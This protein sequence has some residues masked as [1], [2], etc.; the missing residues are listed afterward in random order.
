[1]KTVNHTQKKWLL[2]SCL[3]AAL[4]ANTSLHFSAKE[5]SFDFASNTPQS[6]QLTTAEGVFNVTYIQTGKDQIQAVVAPT[7]AGTSCQG[8]ICGAYTLPMGFDANKENVSKLN[9]AILKEI[10]KKKITAATATAQPEETGTAAAEKAEGHPALAAIL[11]RCESKKESDEAMSCFTKELVKVLNNKRLKIEAAEMNDFF[12]SNVAPLIRS[13]ISHSKTVIQNMMRQKRMSSYQDYFEAAQDS[14]DEITEVERRKEE[15]TENLKSLLE[16]TGSSHARLRSTLLQTQS[17]MIQTYAEQVRQVRAME[18]QNEKTN[19]ALAVQYGLQAT[20]QSQDVLDWNNKLN[21]SN[22]FSMQNL[23]ERKHVNNNEMDLYE[24]YIQ[25]FSR[26]LENYLIAD[27]YGQRGTRIDPRQ[28]LSEETLLAPLAPGMEPR[29]NRPV[30][31]GAGT[32]I[33]SQG[34]QN[35]QGGIISNQQ[36]KIGVPQIATGANGGIQ[37]MNQPYRASQQQIQ[38]RAQIHQLKK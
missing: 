20:Y 38:Q 3:L 2:A 32:T 23:F 21:L 10:E 16:A 27:P 7:E 11:K 34:S 18:K 15:L 8:Q 9:I 12:R 37:V 6:S 4:T 29:G 33:S 14:Q 19:P 28:R 35:S 22:A 36:Q 24:R 25:D 5:G 1:M 30:I 13:E 26:S 17:S 31:P